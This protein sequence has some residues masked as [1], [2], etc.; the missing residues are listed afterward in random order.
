MRLFI[1]ELHPGILEQNGL[2][3][4]LQLRLAA[5]E[6]RA[7]TQVRLVAEEPLEL[8]K[9]LESA[10]YRIALEALNNSMRHAD[11]G[12]VTV[13]LWREQN[14]VLL[15]VADDGCGF[16]PEQHANGGMGLDNMR[17]YASEIGARLQVNSALAQGT[18][19]RVAVPGGRIS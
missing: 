6:G 19:I 4:A 16:D 1:H 8:P 15:E 12:K 13:L 11:A 3:A 10:L 17:L 5:V 18:T 9:D 14:E 2:V 7:D